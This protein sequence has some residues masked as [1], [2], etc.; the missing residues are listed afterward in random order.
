MSTT[1]KPTRLKARRISV[2]RSE[3]E[4]LRLSLEAAGQ[5]FDRLR[6]AMQKTTT[7]AVTDKTSIERAL[8]AAGQD[9]QTLDE[10]F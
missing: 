6:Q 4:Q 1:I 9:N 2:I 3:I 7:T 5:A 8:G 10:L